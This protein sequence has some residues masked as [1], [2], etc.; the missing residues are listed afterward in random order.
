VVDDDLNLWSVILAF[1]LA[2]VT[3]LG[4]AAFAR[5]GREAKV[6]IDE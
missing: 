5:R 2:L 3:G 1:A 6:R 4:V